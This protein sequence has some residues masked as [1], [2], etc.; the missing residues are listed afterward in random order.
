MPI[1]RVPRVTLQNNTSK[2]QFMEKC[3]ENFYQNQ[4]HILEQL[5]F[6]TLNLNSSLAIHSE[7]QV[8][9]IENSVIKIYNESVSYAHTINKVMDIGVEENK[10]SFADILT[11]QNGPSNP[12]SNCSREEKERSNISEI[13]EQEEDGL[14]L[15]K[16]QMNFI[17]ERLCQI[18]RHPSSKTYHAFELSLEKAAEALRNNKVI[19]GAQWL[20]SVLYDAN[21]DKHS[22][23]YHKKIIEDARSLYWLL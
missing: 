21:L 18:Y 4:K 5:K 8:S 15:M 14:A 3:L 7:D 13:L 10:R 12:V 22:R 6:L 1:D 9:L 2:I 11:E 19:E 17:Y 16:S 23:E 20:Q